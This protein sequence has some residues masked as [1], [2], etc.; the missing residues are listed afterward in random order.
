MGADAADEDEGVV[1]AEI[2]DDD[3]VIVVDTAEFAVES[4]RRRRNQMGRARFPDVARQTLLTIRAA[5]DPN[6]YP[7]G[8][9]ITDTELAAALPLARHGWHGNWNY[10]SAPRRL[11]RLG[12]VR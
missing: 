9:R 8:V 7:K 4:I 1:L 3:A 2:Y 6:C 10:T 11:G 5:Y 12:S